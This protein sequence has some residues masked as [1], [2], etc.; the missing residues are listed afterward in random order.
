R[1]A[2]TASRLLADGGQADL[3]T[4]MTTVA[5]DA[6]VIADAAG[7]AAGAN[8]VLA[9]LD[10][11]LGATGSLSVAAVGSADYNAANYRF[12][13]ESGWNSFVTNLYSI[14]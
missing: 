10:E 9:A 14:T 11:A 3:R 5:G 13:A 4:F 6:E 7:L 1:G 2:L 8:A 12:V